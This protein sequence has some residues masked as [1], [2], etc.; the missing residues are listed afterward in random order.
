MKEND[1]NPRRRRRF[2]RTTD[3]DHGG[4]IFPFIA[5][6]FEVH[7]P[8]Q[9]WVA[10]L[11][12]IAIQGGFAYAARILD[13]YAPAERRLAGQRFRPCR[14]RTRCPRTGGP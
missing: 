1:L 9:P 13:A 6:E 14:L 3:S 2:V 4:L 7:G 11:T 10:D 8:D 12:C 5:K